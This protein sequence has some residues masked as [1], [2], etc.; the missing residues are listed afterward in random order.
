M[1]RR[2][3]SSNDDLK[4]ISVFTSDRGFRGADLAA[5]YVH[6][7]PARMAPQIA[8]DALGDVPRGGLV[9]D[10]MCGSGTALRSALELGLAAVGR[11]IDPL[12]VLMSRVATTGVDAQR[13]ERAAANVISRAEA[14][15]RSGDLTLKTIDGEAKAISFVRYWYAP[16]QERQLRALARAL[17]QRASPTNDVLRLAISRTIVT[18]DRGASLTRDVSHSRP[19]RVTKTN[20]FDVMSAFTSSVWRILDAI[21][22]PFGASASVRTGDARSL[23]GIADGSISAVVTSPPYLNAIDY[24][25]GHRLALIWFGVPLAH[26]TRIRSS[27]IGAERAPDASY[28]DARADELLSDNGSANALTPRFRNMFRRFAGDMD[29]VLGETSRVLEADGRAVFVIGNSDNTGSLCRQL[30]SGRLRSTGT[31]ATSRRE[32][33]A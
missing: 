32:R 25:R 1:P 19:H 5:R 9:L 6:P 20:S 21:E 2:C 11:D 24:I 10:P 4:R 27:S 18:K 29:L 3:A 15:E 23:A 17:P 16:E 26:L 12:A 28:D 33:R 31:W 30:C 7:F 8:L 14:L 13:V 22:L